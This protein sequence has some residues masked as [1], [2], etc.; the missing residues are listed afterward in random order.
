ME[1]I[2]RILFNL[3][4][5][6]IKFSEPE[7]PIR[8]VCEHTANELV[9]LVIDQGIGVPH[10]ELT[11]IFELFYRASN[12]D[13][14]RGLGLGLS[15]VKKL[16]QTLDGCVTAESPGPDQGSTFHVRLPINSMQANRILLG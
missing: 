2:K 11:K 1:I 13:T 10:D 15:I 5:N 12:V 7:A 6:A 4:V 3:I 14:R 16:V 9:I 8:V